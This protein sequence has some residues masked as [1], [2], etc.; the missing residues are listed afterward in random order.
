MVTFNTS[1][2]QFVTPRFVPQ[3]GRNDEGKPVRT[4]KRA[5]SFLLQEGGTVVGYSETANAGVVQ[6]KGETV[7]TAIGDKEGQTPLSYTRK[8]LEAKLPN[9]V[10]SY[11]QLARESANTPH[12]P[13]GNYAGILHPD[14]PNAF[15]I[16]HGN[17]PV[18]ELHQTIQESNYRLPIQEHFPDDKP[19]LRQKLSKVSLRGNGKATAG[20]EEY[21]DSDNEPSS[22]AKHKT[23]VHSLRKKLSSN[24][25]RRQF[26]STSLRRQFSSTSLGRTGTDEPIPELPSIKLPKSTAEVLA[27]RGLLGVGQEPTALPS[28]KILTPYPND[29]KR[30]E[31]GNDSNIFRVL[32]HR[33]SFSMS[34]NGQQG[35]TPTGENTT[36]DVV[37]TFSDTEQ[38]AVISIAN[39]LEADTL[40]VI[41][42]KNCA[43]TD[44][45]P[46]ATHPSTDNVQMV[47]KKEWPL[48][49]NVHADIMAAL[50]LN[51]LD[52]VADAY[53]RT[54]ET[55]PEDL[56]PSD[57]D[58]PGIL[59]I[60]PAVQDSNGKVYNVST[61]HEMSTKRENNAP[62]S[63]AVQDSN[64]NVYNVD[65][66]HEMSTQR[67]NKAPVSP[68]DRIKRKIFSAFSP[69][70]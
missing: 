1:G 56:P 6:Q 24:S 53:Q 44:K 49:M 57:P 37:V 11:D 50:R 17:D 62:V 45:Y 54:V 28:G 4:V 15:I 14:G 52:N 35:R 12:E 36:Y 55:T 34:A 41:L 19:T 65:T 5:K 33:A 58:Y 46:T 47:V 16:S 13:V 26:S 2:S 25:L 31:V 51:G 9:I 21:S 48:G 3:V 61:L 32:A 23:S 22:S 59:N 29:F 42:R 27:E 70:K 38:T 20:H 69:N 64:E 39:P 63:P 66:L 30:E 67:G 8:Y 18:A 7:F 68:A 43:F 60:Q 10:I 40:P